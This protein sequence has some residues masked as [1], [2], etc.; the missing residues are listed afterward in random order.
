MSGRNETE[1]SMNESRAEAIAKASAE[2]QAEVKIVQARPLR[3]LPAAWRE[4]GAAERMSAWIKR[5][6]S[7]R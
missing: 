3:V 6:G 4:P 7:V 2:A 1:Q 5:F